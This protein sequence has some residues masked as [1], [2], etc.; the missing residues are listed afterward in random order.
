MLRDVKL[1]LIRATVLILA[2]AITGWLL[3]V[4]TYIPAR[5]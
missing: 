5:F 1:L 4:M 2:V 3:G